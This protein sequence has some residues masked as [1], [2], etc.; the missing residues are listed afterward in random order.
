MSG[1]G[2][3]GES[4][5]KISKT[6]QFATQCSCNYFN[7]FAALLFNPYNIVIGTLQEVD[8]LKLLVM[9]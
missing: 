2:I 6:L 8:I 5:A 7:R 1:T 4:I 9:G 3:Y